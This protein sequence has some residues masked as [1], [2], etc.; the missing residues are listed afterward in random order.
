V[1]PRTLGELD[2]DGAI[3]E[4]LSQV[5]GVTRG[6]FLATL[7]LGSAALLGELA[8]PNAAG[9]STLTDRQILNFALVLEYLQA[10]F[11]SEAERRKPL[12]KGTL[13]TIPVHLGAVERAHVA[14]F[15]QALGSAAVKRPSFDFGGT[16]EQATPFLKTAIALE[17]LAVAAYK[18]QAGNIKS[19]AY[20]AAAISIH[21]VE[22][23]HA[24]WMRYLLGRQ[25]AATAFDKPIS[26]TG[27]KKLVA[28]THFIVAK[29]ATSGRTSPRFTG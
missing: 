14:A 26:A 10:A 5:C 15:R 13:A 28:S 18:G 9:A 19:A 11:Y 8:R 24:A 4:A 21:S 12:T 3:E 7:G 2:R 23:R 25:P 16:T 6:R 29:P 1:S 27:A 20:L 22:A 17:D